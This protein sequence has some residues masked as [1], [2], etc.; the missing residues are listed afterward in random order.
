MP[1]GYGVSGPE[2]DR[3]DFTPPG[4]RTAPPPDFA[5]GT[6]GDQVSA[7]PEGWHSTGGHPAVGQHV[8]DQQRV[9][10]R[11]GGQHSPVDRFAGSHQDDVDLSQLPPP[12]VGQAPT[13]PP[14]PQQYRSPQPYRAQRAVPED[15]WSGVSTSAPGQ[16]RP[17]TVTTAGVLTITASALWT[18]SI[19]FAWL[20]L[21]ALR[22]DL[23]SSGDIGT[24]LYHRITT[25]HHTLTF[26]AWI[27]A[28]GLPL[29]AT[30]V[31]LVM[32]ARVRWTQWALTGLGLAS[33]I[34]SWTVLGTRGIG[35][36]LVCYV[37][38]TTA[39]IWTPGARR[40]FAGATRSTASTAT[41]FDTTP[42]HH[43]MEP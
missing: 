19:G 26:G 32:F 8:V 10:Q 42:S 3:P 35:I 16:Q 9:D 12:N 27:P 6:S 41:N 21:L 28:F 30:I 38:F 11:H 40:W 31:A 24:A 22:D 2:F 39:L 13:R 18:C 17:A 23:A 33:V 4:N 20:V 14:S 34:A 5:P 25:I 36:P 43:R 7:W 1:R 29:A 37:L 15:G